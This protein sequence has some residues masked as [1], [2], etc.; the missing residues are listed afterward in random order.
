MEGILKE[1]LDCHLASAVVAT[2]VMIFFG[3]GFTASTGMLVGR[4]FGGAILYK[5]IKQEN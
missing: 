1:L 3:V 5:L 2:C 4:P